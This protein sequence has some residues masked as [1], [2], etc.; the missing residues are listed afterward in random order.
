MQDQV[1]VHLTEVQ[2]TLLITLRAKALDSHSKNPILNDEKA[3]QLLSKIDYDF[4][5]LK[6]FGND[7]FIVVRAK[8]YDEWLREFLNSNPTAV[9]LNLGCGLDT[10]IT[11]INPSATIQW[12][13][14][15]YPDVIQ[16][17]ENFYSNGAGY[18]MI[19]SSITDPNWLAE[20]PKDQPTIIIAEG[21]LEYLTAEE[22]KSLLN[23]MTDHFLHG[24]MAF[25]VMNAYAIEEAGRS[26]ANQTTGAL[27]KWV[28]E[29]L[30]EVDKLD[31][32]LER[33]T[34]LSLFKSPYVRKLPWVFRLFYGSMVL[35]PQYKNM[36]RLL[37]Y[38]F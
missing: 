25:D 7:N 36:I 18:K 32:K 24:E 12:F 11:R 23:R 28:V 22:A 13:D 21:V 6:S 31:A 33:V 4:G 35:V 17:R 9:V 5:K 29:S 37:R 30:E 26:R 34:D 27:H 38:E 14:I 15:D 3:S 19:G 2:E 1:K 10:R 16:L 8:Q 20:I